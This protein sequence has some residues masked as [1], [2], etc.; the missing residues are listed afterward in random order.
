MDAVDAVRRFNSWEFTERK[1]HMF[2]KIIIISL[3]HI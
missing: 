3:I 1:T 2:R